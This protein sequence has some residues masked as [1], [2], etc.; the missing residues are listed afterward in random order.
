M[1]NTVT[2]TPTCIR[3][4][5]VE[6]DTVFQKTIA[7]AIETSTDIFLT[8]VAST[9][10]E[11]LKMLQGAAADVLLVD[12]DLPDGSG[13]D[14]I[15]AA[16]TRWPRCNVMVSTVFG[17]QRH[18]MRSLEAGAVGYLLKDSSQQSMLIE[19]RN[20]HAGGSPISPLIARQILTQFCPKV[21]AVHHE[22]QADSSNT[23]STRLSQREQQVLELVTKG[24]TAEEIATLI[25]VTR[26]TVLTFVR[27]IYK[28]LE[29]NS[30]AEAIFEAHKLGLLAS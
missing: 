11:G 6:D 29:V 15:G 26:Q 8:A 27:R 24:F 25:G 20:L 21:G 22:A 30:K 1:Q 23:P 14:V 17:D 13:V 12:L 18:V 9:R 2:S 5:M 7:R 28:K 4:A 3:V 16:Q 19:I 10:S